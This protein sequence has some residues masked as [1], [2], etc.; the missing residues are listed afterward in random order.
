MDKVDAQLCTQPGSAVLGGH[1]PG[2]SPK[3]PARPK[4]A[5]SP[6]GCLNIALASASSS[7]KG[8]SSPSL[9]VCKS[10]QGSEPSTGDESTAQ[11]S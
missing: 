10:D 9:V 6:S 5:V 8:D 4:Q 1:N 3:H 2:T 7:I 11:M